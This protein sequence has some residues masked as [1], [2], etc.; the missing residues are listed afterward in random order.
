VQEKKN[1]TKAEEQKG[2]SVTMQ[3]LWGDAVSR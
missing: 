1:F 3:G 2:V